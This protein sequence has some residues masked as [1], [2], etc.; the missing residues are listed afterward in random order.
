[1]PN[2]EWLRLRKNN[3][4]SAYTNIGDAGV[5]HLSKGKWENLRLISLSIRLLIKTIRVLGKCAQSGLLKENG[6]NW[7]EYI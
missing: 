5:L 6:R 4:Y 3:Y 7:N 2:L 1:M